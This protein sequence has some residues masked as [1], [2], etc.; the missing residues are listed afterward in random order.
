[1]DHSM[2]ILE[3]ST[4]SDP[5]IKRTRAALLSALLSLLEEKAFDQITIRDIAGR[6][7]IGYA[8]FFRNY[9]SKGAVLHE[10]A[11]DQIRQLIDLAFPAI[12]GNNGRAAALALCTFVDEHRRL[13]TALLTGGAAGIVREEFIRQGA[14]VKTMSSRR[15]WLPLELANIVGVSATV[16][17]LAWWLQRGRGVTVEKMA[18]ILDRLVI[19][20]LVKPREGAR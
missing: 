9:D 7:D 8:T 5:R 18:R 13:W 11:A 2:D 14:Q 17:I 12:E 6:A 20:P 1:M 4:P 3:T 19:S 16:E 15:A 10:L